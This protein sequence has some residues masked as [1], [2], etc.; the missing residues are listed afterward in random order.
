MIGSRLDFIFGQR[1][2]FCQ[3]EPLINQIGKWKI[4]AGECYK[5]GNYL[6][7]NSYHERIQRFN[8]CAEMISRFPLAYWGVYANGKIVDAKT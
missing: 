5:M 7:H 4:V 2:W 1:L 3:D 8:N 6:L